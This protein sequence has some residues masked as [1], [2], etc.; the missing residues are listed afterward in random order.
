MQN[1]KKL[2]PAILLIIL[3]SLFALHFIQYQFKWIKVKPLDGYYIDAEKIKFSWKNW[4]SGSYREAEDEYLNDHFGFRSFFIR[5][6]HQL[7]FSLFNKVKT[8]WVIV[9]K[10]NYLYEHNYIKAVYGTDFIGHDSIATRMYK[11]R[12]LQDAL[13]HLGKKIIIV[14]ASGKGSFYPEYIPDN[15]YDERGITN[16]EV[17]RHYIEKWK[18]NCI[19]FNQ[20]FI[21][22][23]EKSPY[24]LYP[25]Y[26]IHWSHYSTC[27]ATD[28][29]VRYIEKLCDIEMPRIYWEKI[30]LDWPQK[31]DNDISEAM[32]LLFPPRSFKMAYPEIKFESDSGKT[33]PSL[34]VVA[35]SFYR[36]IFDLEL[37]NLFSHHRFWYYNKEIYPECF[38]S[39]LTTDDINVQEEI[40][41]YDIIIILGTDA[42]LPDFGWG[43]IENGYNLFCSQK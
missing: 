16:I 26:G 11:F 28:S 2:I 10:S 1:R 9:G 4:F 23:K 30:N 37:D 32:N 43:F 42:T 15:Y 14:F 3:T 20:Y 39:W 24:S 35:D 40:L 31:G 5:I 21:D 17:Y 7:R 19:D 27:L 36:G 29:I 12:A 41:K 38:H 34:L 25:Q 8:A 13:D 33:K 6:N 22:L 18:I